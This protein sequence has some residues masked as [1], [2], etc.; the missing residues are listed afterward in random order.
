MH[1]EPVALLRIASAAGRVR[2]ATSDALR[3]ACPVA[4][5]E[6]SPGELPPTTTNP[7]E[8]R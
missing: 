1:D 3:L 6:S 7:R 4:E 5:R 2:A 8:P